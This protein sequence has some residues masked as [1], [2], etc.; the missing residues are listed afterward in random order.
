MLFRSIVDAARV[1]I[2]PAAARWFTA[3][4]HD[5]VAAAVGGGDDY[6]LLFAVRPNR[7][8]RLRQVLRLAQVAV[9]KIGVCTADKAVVLQRTSGDGQ[10]TQD[11][12]PEPFHHFR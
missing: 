6:E 4:G 12:L 7:S 9:T 8:G 1:P 5:A 11:P 3:A 2:N 10:V